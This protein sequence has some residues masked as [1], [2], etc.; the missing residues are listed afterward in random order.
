VFA[1]FAQTSM[2]TGSVVDVT[3]IGFGKLIV[4]FVE[5]VTLLRLNVVP[6]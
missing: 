5:V 4:E 1:L 6:P 2:I 3:L